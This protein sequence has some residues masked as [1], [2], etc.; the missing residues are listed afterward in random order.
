MVARKTG[1]SKARVGELTLNSK[2]QL[3]A[4]ELYLIAKAVDANPGD[5]INELYGHLSLQ[6]D[7]DQKG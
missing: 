3:R 5:L 2:A 1:L 6:N 7:D 4:D